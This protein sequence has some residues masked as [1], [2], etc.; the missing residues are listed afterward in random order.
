MEIPNFAQAGDVVVGSYS[1]HGS[2]TQK[3]TVVGIG[4]GAAEQLQRSM[5]AHAVRSGADT[6]TL[7]E[8]L[9]TKKKAPAKKKRTQKKSATPVVLDD[10]DE[11][12]SIQNLID[13]PLPEDINAEYLESI[14][15]ESPPAEII[16]PIHQQ[17]I[18]KLRVRMLTEF[19]QIRMQVEGVLE[20]PMAIGLIF[21]NDDDIVFIPTAGQTLRLLLPNDDTYQVYYPD[22]LFDWT[23]TG[24]KLM[25]LI[26][27]ED[28]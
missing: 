21:S 13:D 2:V 18:E 9:D 26:K 3:D 25:I 22:V 4:S 19:G 24:K 8:S 15:H 23:D 28:E 20:C 12:I 5:L 14:I 6:K 17:E 1:P 7:K 27:Q 11:L 16:K 10:L